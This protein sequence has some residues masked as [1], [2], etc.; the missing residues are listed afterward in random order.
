MASIE[1][2][3]NEI[4]K[5]KERNARVEA[6]KAWEISWTRKILIFILTYLV[7]VLFFYFAGLP[8]PLPNAIVPAAAFV[9]STMTIPYIKGL[10]IR[11]IYKK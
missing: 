1:E 5:I 3:E 8:N 6:D 10:W 9:I 2:L 11:R 7:I 4:A